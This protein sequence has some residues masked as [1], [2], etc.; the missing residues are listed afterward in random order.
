MNKTNIEWCESTWNPV[1]GCVHGCEYCYARQIVNRFSTSNKCHTFTDGHPYMRIN[2]VD[3][4]ELDNQAEIFTS[5]GKDIHGFVKPKFK[6]APYPFGFEPTLHRYKLD[7]VQKWKKGRNIFVCS[8]ADLFGAWAPDSWIEEVFSA[9]EKAPQH[10]YLFLTKNPQRYG[11]LARAGKLPQRSNMWYGSTLDSMKAKRYPGRLLD[12]TF[13]SIEPL[14]EYMDVG[15][16][17][18]GRDQ[19]VIIGAETGNRK[20][21]VTPRKEWID[22]ICKAA[23]ITHM[24]VFMKDSLIPVVGEENMRREFPWDRQTLKNAADYADT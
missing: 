20:G 8:M 19:W 17:S 3:L 23:D 22:K 16:G 7:E 24:A 9:C 14:T 21:R 2:G 5:F 13:I 10:R 1:T 6:K 4:H 12:N 15:P 18:F 11:E